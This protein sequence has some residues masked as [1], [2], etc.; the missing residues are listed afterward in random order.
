MSLQNSIKISYLHKHEFWLAI[1][2][3][4]VQQAK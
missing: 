3:N 4:F 1:G 2:N